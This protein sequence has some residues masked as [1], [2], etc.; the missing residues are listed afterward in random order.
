MGGSDPAEGMLRSSLG[1]GD[2][3]N[4]LP[5]AGSVPF[6]GARKKVVV[7]Q[8]QGLICWDGGA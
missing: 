4:S 1:T 6:A 3:W 7:S 5:E 2:H 8:D